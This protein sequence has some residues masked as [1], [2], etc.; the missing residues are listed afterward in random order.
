MITISYDINFEFY[1]KYIFV[2]KTEL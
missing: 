2:Y 1:K